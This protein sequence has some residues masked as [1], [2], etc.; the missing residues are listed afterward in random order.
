MNPN[1]PKVASRAR[2]ICEYCHAPE[3]VFN[4]PFEVEH[5]IPLSLKGSNTEENLALSCRSC[6]LYKSDSIAG[7]DKTSQQNVGFFNPRT[8]DW[9]KHFSIDEG[10]G[11]IESLSAVGR[12][13]ISILRINSPAQIAARVQWLKLELF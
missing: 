5:I 12:V 3:V 7:F 10:T 6:N 9:R 2:H 1:Y 4:F 11:R 8:D 13:T